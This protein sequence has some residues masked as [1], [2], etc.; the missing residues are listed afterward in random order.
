MDTLFGFGA[1]QNDGTAASREG[2][3]DWAQKAFVAC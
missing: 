3:M 1:R 2:A